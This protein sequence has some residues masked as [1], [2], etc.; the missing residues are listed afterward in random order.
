MQETITCQGLRLDAADLVWLQNWIKQHHDWSRKRLAF[1]LCRQWDWCTPTGRLKNYAARSFLLKMEQRGFIVLPPIRTAMRRPTW[2]ASGKVSL[3]MPTP[4]PITT[5]LAKLRP[6]TLVLPKS[7]SF[8]NQRFVHYLGQYHYLG[9]NR[10]V[11]ENIK[12]LVR[13][14]YGRDIACVLFGSA[15][16]KTAPRDAFIGWSDTQRQRNINS[17]TNNTRFL[18]L[19]WVTVP[20]LASHILGL[21]LRRLRTDWIS[22]YGH[23][24]H[25][26]ETFV[27]RDRFQGTCYRAANWQCVGQTQGRSRQ[28]RYTS[29]RVPV[30]DIYLYPL[31]P[32][33]RQ[34]LSSSRG[35]PSC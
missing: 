7:G 5:P 25:L 16:W 4:I 24:V 8:E 23:P 21:V 20:H 22:K 14:H 26:V 3:A 11:G 13:D 10:T 15:A 33:F 28:D 2:S 32:H 17:L 18:I 9:F 30:K 19:P 29:M 6:F 27:E 12:Y 34:A 1:E 35:D 31:I